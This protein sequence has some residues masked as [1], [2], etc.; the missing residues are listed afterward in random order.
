MSRQSRVFIVIVVLFLS[1]VACVRQSPGPVI[2]I[3]ATPPDPIGVQTRT[4]G[5]LPADDADTVPAQSSTLI[6]PTLDPL[7]SNTPEALPDTYVV[8]P[9]DF[10]SSIADRFGATVEALMETNGIED[11][12]LI[13]VGQ[14]LRLPATSSVYSPAVK[15]LPDS[16]LVRG[17]ATANFDIIGY[18]AG[19]PG[20]LR[21]YT[22]EVD[23]E[24]IP[25]AEIVRRVAYDYSVNPRVLLALIEYR[26]GWL[27]DPEPRA[28][29][30][31]YPLGYAQLGYEGLERQLA[32]TAN[33]LNEA[34]YGY[35]VRGELWFTF[36]DGVRVLY[37]DGLNAGTVAVQYFLS[38][39]RAYSAWLP[40]VGPTGFYG[41]YVGLFGDP[42][43][44][45]VE[46]LLPADLT[47]PEL[48]L[49]WP[50]GEL[51]YYT[52]GPH[53]SYGTGSAWGALDFAPPG[54]EDTTGCFIAPQWATAA[55]AGLIARS[56][57]GYVILDLDGDGDET[58]GWVLVYLHLAAQD[59]MP[60]G[61][62]VQAGDVLGHPSCE[63]GVS[64][65]THLHITRRYNGEWIE[66][67]CHQCAPN[68]PSVPFVMGGWTVQGWEGQEYQGSMVNGEE[69]RQAE[70]GR[71]T[72]INELIWDK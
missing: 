34:Y 10:L 67:Q 13:A 1:A 25:A 69:Y 44:Q 37:G 6:V 65:A 29:T 33:R 42:F 46:P 11:A 57:R 66:A 5:T 26:S 18:V 55:T 12:E 28:A 43:A 59:R 30:L 56:E 41:L 16:E 48:G 64:N 58:T 9:G 23:G 15:I 20:F 63:G 38:R 60:A 35:R 71:D 24:V 36:G 22:E 45:A 39:N 31:V 4:P 14:V 68:V 72:P 40:E 62:V 17:P 27:F 32:W 19:L 7:R 52:G 51:W 53:G 47:Q 49:P 8:Q 54:D 3:T 50:A 21:D 2:I 61:V 70:Q